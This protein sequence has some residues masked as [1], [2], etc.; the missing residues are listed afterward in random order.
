MRVI[1]LLDKPPTK[2]EMIEL[3]QKR[4][5]IFRVHN[6]KK[7]AKQIENLLNCFDCQI[8]DC[9]NCR[10]GESCCFECAANQGHF[11]RSSIII[12]HEE[13]VEDV[14]EE[15]VSKMD[16]NSGSFL[17]FNGCGLPI[18]NRSTT[19]LLYNCGLKEDEQGSLLPKSKELYNILSWMENMANHFEVYIV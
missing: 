3:L 13:K 9:G 6:W 18:K 8:D 19:C 5:V 11:L 12:D 14:F 1:P 2:D 16:D 15:I 4:T 7:I 17:R 10:E